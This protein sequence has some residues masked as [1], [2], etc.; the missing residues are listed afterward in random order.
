MSNAEFA[1][2]ESVNLTDTDRLN[3]I[4]K[5]MEYNAKL[6]LVRS[7]ME[8]NQAAR[9]RATASALCAM[10]YMAKS[11]EKIMMME[12]ELQEAEGSPVWGIELPN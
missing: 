10:Y 12:C 2:S 3:I 5:Y 8:P 11:D 6:S 7:F 1:T 9:H 4:L